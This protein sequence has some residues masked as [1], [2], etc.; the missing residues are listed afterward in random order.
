M[1]NQKDERIIELR[2]TEAGIN[3]L[4]QENRALV[5][6]FVNRR[7]FSTWKMTRDEI[8]SAGMIG[9]WEAIVKY[10]PSRGA[11]STIASW[12]IRARV[13]REIQL[14]EMEH[15]HEAVS[16]DAL[17]DCDFAKSTDDPLSEDNE[18]YKAALDK[19]N[20]RTRSIIEARLNGKTLEE[21]A[22]GYKVS[23]E[24]IR[25]I[26]LDGVKKMRGGRQKFV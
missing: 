18:F 26:F 2:K 20:N 23:R 4:L 7:Y 11:F 13:S 6:H 1:Q 22:K 16:M 3:Q 9:L 12:R 15:L 10:D 24:R 19:L 8:F 25:Q 5:H 21:I 14:R 17:E